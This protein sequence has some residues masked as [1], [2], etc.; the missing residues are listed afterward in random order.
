MNLAESML[1]RLPRTE[2]FILPHGDYRGQK[3]GTVAVSAEG[4]L[5]LEWLAQRED[6]EA[7]AK[8][9]LETYLNDWSIRAQLQALKDRG[10]A[11]RLEGKR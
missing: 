3:I 10:T 11:R 6:L 9:A 5:S 4:L 8:L 1:Y 2:D 7:R